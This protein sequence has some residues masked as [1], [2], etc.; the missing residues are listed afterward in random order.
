M[1]RLRGRAPRGKRLYA[2]APQSHW[3][4]TTMICSMRW[5]GSTACM[6]VDGATDTEVFRAYVQ[7]VLCPTL[8]TGDVVIMD[9]LSPHKSTQTIEL[10]QQVGAQVIFLPPYSPDLN[11]V[12]KMWSKL[13]EFLRS[14]ECSAS[15]YFRRFSH[16]NRDG[17]FADRGD[18]VASAELLN[19][20]SRGNPPGGLR[21]QR[22]VR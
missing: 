14:K 9:N 12:E 2:S 7:E 13:K 21:I 5:D 6:A 22:F 3:Y 19:V 11:P 10:I 8:R 1:T 15:R 4:T 17:I 18:F 20:E 16:N